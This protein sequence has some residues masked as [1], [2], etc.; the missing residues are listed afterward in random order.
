MRLAV[1][2]CCLI[3]GAQP[4]ALWQPRGVMWGGRWEG[5]SRGKGRM[6]P[7]GW[8]ML[9]YGRKQ[10]NIVKKYPPIK[11]KLRKTLGCRERKKRIWGMRGPV[12]LC[13]WAK[14]QSQEQVEMPSHPSCV[15]SLCSVLFILLKWLFT[16]PR[17]LEWPCWTL[18]NLKGLRRIIK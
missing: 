12:N 17:R 4:G 11:N 5:D 2:I 9:M 8:F 13:V 16:F 1:G 7:Y 10:H 3:Q 15:N 6:C 18:C 14:L